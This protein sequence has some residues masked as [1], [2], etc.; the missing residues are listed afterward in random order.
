MNNFY[1][2]SD[3]MTCNDWNQLVIDFHNVESNS[4]LFE[5]LESLPESTTEELLTNVKEI[6]K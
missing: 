6:S 4:S 5:Y 2:L 3:S 1:R